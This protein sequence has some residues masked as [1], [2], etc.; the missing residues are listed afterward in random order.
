MQNKNNLYD[1]IRS[2]KCLSFI[3]RLFHNINIVSF[4]PFL[5]FVLIFILWQQSFT[6]KISINV[7]LK[8]PFLYCTFHNISFVSF[9][10]FI[11]RQQSLTTIISIK[12]GLNLYRVYGL[13]GL[14]L[15]H[16]TVKSTAKLITHAFTSP[17]FLI[18]VL[19][20]KTFVKLQMVINMTL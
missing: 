2:L 14:M 12:A 7:F 6:T 16:V 9:F 11:L 15:M 3:A 1:K 13:K 5:I 17:I 4:L 18:S 19:L 10:I 8:I 20:N